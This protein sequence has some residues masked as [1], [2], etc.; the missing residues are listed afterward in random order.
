MF[1]ALIAYSLRLWEGFYMLIQITLNFISIFLISIIGYIVLSFSVAG[2]GSIGLNFSEFK[3]FL[4]KSAAFD[5]FIVTAIQISAGSILTCSLLQVSNHSVISLDIIF[6]LSIL[7][8]ILYH[9]LRQS[10]YTLCKTI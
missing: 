1:N 8:L 5:N 3:F 9:T 10:K 7:M 6:F 2:I 4:E